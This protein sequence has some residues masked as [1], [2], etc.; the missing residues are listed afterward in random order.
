MRRR[1]L[2][3]LDMAEEAQPGDAFNSFVRFK[4]QCAMCEQKL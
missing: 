2:E 4:V 3:Y 1:A